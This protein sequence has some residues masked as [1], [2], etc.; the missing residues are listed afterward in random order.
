[1]YKLGLLAIAAAL[2]ACSPYVQQNWAAAGGSAPDKLS[3]RVNP[4]SGGET[5]VM[6]TSYPDF[7]PG[8]RVRILADGSVVPL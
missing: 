2:S 1:M 3:V 5:Q 4:D 8:D 6:P 7:R